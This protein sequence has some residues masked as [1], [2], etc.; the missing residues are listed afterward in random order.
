MPES[1]T[2]LG[3]LVKIKSIQES[4]FLQYNC[5]TDGNSA[6]SL[7]WKE[8]TREIQYFWCFTMN[9]SISTVGAILYSM[10]IDCFIWAKYSRKDQVKFVEDSL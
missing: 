10:E 1:T 7:Y 2:K 4:I 6:I 9:L 3:W 8:K 5:H